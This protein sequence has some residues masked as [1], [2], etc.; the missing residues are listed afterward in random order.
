MV[1]VAV[2]VLAVVEQ[3]ERPVR[4]QVMAVIDEPTLSG[5]AVA[6]GRTGACA[7]ELPIQSPGCAHLHDQVRVAVRDREAVVERE[8]VDRVRVIQPRIGGVQVAADRERGVQR[9]VR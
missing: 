8:V 9:A 3:K 6:R 7:A 5:A 1:D 4:Q 2:V